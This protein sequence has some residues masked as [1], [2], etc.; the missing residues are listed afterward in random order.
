MWCQSFHRSTL[1]FLGV[2]ETVRPCGVGR[3]PPPEQTHPSP[4]EQWIL[5]ESLQAID[6]LLDGL[7]YPQIGQRLNLSLGSVHQ[8]MSEALCCYEEL[9]G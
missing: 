4:Q 9:A 2:S 1:S 6:R 8:L 7:T 3:P 5:V